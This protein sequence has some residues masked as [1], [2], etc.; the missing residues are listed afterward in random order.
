[1]KGF[2]RRAPVAAAQRWVC[3]AAARLESE[4]V[5][6]AD[7]LGRVLAEDP[8]A[9]MDVPPFDRSAMDGFAVRST[10]LA[11]ATGYDPVPLR[12]I[13]QSL[14]GQPTVPEVLPRTAVRI[15]TG[16]PLPKGADAVVPAE[17]ARQDDA[18]MVW[19]ETAV[20][21]GKHIGRR[22][23]DVTRG[24]VLFRA[25][26]R[27]LP[28]DLGVLASTGITRLRV[29]RQPR[30]R[31]LIT[32][33][34]LAP[35][36]HE[37]QKH[38]I[39]DANG[40]MLHA[41][42]RRDGARLDAVVHVPDDRQRLRRAI[43]AGCKDADVLL[44]SGG[45]S[46]GSEDYAP[47]LVAELGEL[48]IHGVAIRPAAPTGIGRIGSTLVFLLPGN[49]VSCLC[50]YDFFAGPAI[51]ALQGLPFRWPYRSRV[52]PLARKIASAL[53]RVDYCRVRIEAGR[54]FPLAVSGAS[55]LT[56]TT[57]ADGFVVVP[58]DSEG[59]P[60]DTPVRVF[61]YQPEGITD[62]DDHWIH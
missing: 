44:I 30:V 52:L 54:V 18:G 37:R 9:T 33:N 62:G 11:G 38:Q 20:P 31:L 13:G 47:L 4:Y 21:A 59:F 48:P 16:A 19:I 57:R 46:V 1:M 28:Q 43:A 60:P 53:G 22:G 24:T 27:L 40:P 32:G 51:R 10:D 42:A 56:S 36:G 39:H 58:E 61:L 26:R 29:V 23:E 17:F 41:L 49:P 25:G 6:L 14:P 35:A 15:M 50:A 12:V 5:T 55:I 3:Q 45:S 8:T 2:A 7:A 34:E